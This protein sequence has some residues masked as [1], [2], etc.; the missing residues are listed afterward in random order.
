ML[1][2]SKEFPECFSRFC[3]G[4]GS[5]RSLSW[6]LLSRR[7]ELTMKLSWW[8]ILSNLWGFLQDEV[9]A[10]SK[11]KD[12]IRIL[13]SRC[14]INHKIA[15]GYHEWLLRSV[16]ISYHLSI[17]ERLGV[18]TFYVINYSNHN[19][20]VEAIIVSHK[21]FMSFGYYLYKKLLHV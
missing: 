11:D 21:N 2:S 1:L 20:Y 4:K 13:S 6:K 3:L 9:V 19:S 10:S 14:P 17:L 5:C 12:G 7:K 15:M 18:E 16:L 8:P